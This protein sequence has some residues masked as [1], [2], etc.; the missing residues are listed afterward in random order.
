MLL[1]PDHATI[2]ALADAQGMDAEKL[3][4]VALAFPQ[5]FVPPQPQPQPQL[6]LPVEALGVPAHVPMPEAMVEP[7][8]PE[9][10]VPAEQPQVYVQPRRHQRVREVL[11]VEEEE[12]FF[13]GPPPPPPHPGMHERHHRE[14]HGFEHHQQRQR[15]KRGYGYGYAEDMQLPPSKVRVSSPSSKAA[16]PHRVLIRGDKEGRHDK[17]P[18]RPA[19]EDG[20][21]ASAND[22]KHKG[23]I[24]HKAMRSSR[25]S[26]E[27]TTTATATAHSHPPPTSSPHTQSQTHSQSLEG[28]TAAERFLNTFDPKE[29]LQ[30]HKPAAG[31]VASTR[32][33]S[34]GNNNA[35]RRAQPREQSVRTPAQRA[36]AARSEHNVSRA[37]VRKPARAANDGGRGSV[38]PQA[39]YRGF[40][41]FPMHHAHA[42]TH[43]PQY[44]A[45]PHR[46]AMYDDPEMEMQMEMEMEPPR[47]QRS[48]VDVQRARRYHSHSHGHPSPRQFHAQVPYVRTRSR[49]PVGGG[50]DGDA[51][52][53]GDDGIH[54]ANATANANAMA[55]Y[56]ERSPQAVYSRAPPGAAAHVHPRYAYRQTPAPAPP[57][58]YAVPMPARVPVAGGR[59]GEVY[60]EEPVPVPVDVEYG[61]GYGYDEYPPPPPPASGYA[62]DGERRV[63]DVGYA[64]EMYA[65]E[66]AGMVPVARPRSRM[67][68]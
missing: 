51:E 48:V 62:Y 11:P 32:E 42:H 20:E 16:Y 13:P 10:L 63:R 36:V 33:T 47:R 55:Y 68:Y 43:S 12:Y 37:G 60:Y 52:G 30:G 40:V 46:G 7:M 56:R 64:E 31:G 1:L 41:D 14:V 58:G 53:V 4:L 6:Q 59:H 15:L 5:V 24:K 9:P 28:M 23:K 21:V 35:G 50:G 67:V 3:R 38:P 66:M 54:D 26:P 22:D 34:E 45:Y 2:A 8:V 29:E 39:Y 25:A 61:Y 49:S 57:P 19:S 27:H 17:R 65:E 44:P 18:S